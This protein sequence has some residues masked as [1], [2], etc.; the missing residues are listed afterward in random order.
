[1]SRHVLKMI[2]PPINVQMM[3]S[4]HLTITLMNEKTYPWFYS[5]FIQ[6]KAYPSELTTNHTSSVKFFQGKVDSNPWLNNHPILD[7]DN[8]DI[9]RAIKECIDGNYYVECPLDEY[10]LTSLRM[11]G[12]KHYFHKVM[13]YGYDDLEELFY[14]VGYRKNQTYGEAACTFSEFKKALY[15]RIPI[16]KSHKEGIK[17][18]RVPELI[19]EPEVD[20]E[21]IVLLLNDYTNGTNSLGAE[22]KSDEQEDVPVYGVNVYGFLR[23]S[24]GFLLA[25]VGQMD[26]RGYHALMEHKR[27]MSRRLEFLASKN[28]LQNAGEG[29]R[30]YHN[31][32]KLAEKLRNHAIL[33]TIKGSEATLRT[34]ME[35]LTHI[36]DRETGLLHDIK[37]GLAGGKDH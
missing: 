32:E 19:A 29:I 20:I 5:N 14:I 27:V 16:N 24:L 4:Y 10:Y 9:I 7:E 17:K 35:Y 2:N 21:R 30:S 3:Y 6:L 11:G 25:G 31:I 18:F 34:M 13:I 28:Y 15:S 8:T 1:M 36:E 26:L 22:K 37:E 12:T 33:Y 23:S